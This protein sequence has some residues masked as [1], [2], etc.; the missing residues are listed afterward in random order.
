MLP[1]TLRVKKY[2][3]NRNYFEAVLMS[4]DVVAFDPFVSC[5]IELSDNDYHAGKGE[6]LVGKNFVI[7]GF[8]VQPWAEYDERYQYMVIPYEGEIK[9]M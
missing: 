4:G 8:C 5:A 9:E 6:D 3:K 1:I 2:H 7:T